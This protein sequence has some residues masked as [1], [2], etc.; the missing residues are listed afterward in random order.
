MRVGKLVA[1]IALGGA[2]VSSTALAA[3]GKLID[4]GVDGGN[5]I[6]YATGDVLNPKALLIRVT[7]TPQANVE[8]LSIVTCGKGKKK[9]KAPDQL[10]TLYPT[11]TQKLRKGY[12]RPS[13][14]TVDVQAAYEDAGIIG[15]IKI[16][17]FAR[18][19]KAKRVKR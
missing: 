17:I 15:D 4:K 8:V 7:A 2:L 1:T 19:K 18:G 11:A 16:E 13:D 5:P 12:K 9:V 14:C 6:A 3:P 10:F